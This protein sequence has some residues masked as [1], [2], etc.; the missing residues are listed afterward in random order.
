MATLIPVLLDAST[1]AAERRVAEALRDQLPADWVVV[2]GQRLATSRRGGTHLREAEIDVLVLAPGLG[3]ACLE[4]K[5]GREVGCDGGGWYSVDERGARHDIKDPGRQAQQSVHQLVD[6][7]RALPAPSLPN[8]V[9]PFVWGVVLPG[10][11]VDRDVGPA[12]PRSLV[13]DRRDLADPRTAFERLFQTVPAR[14]RFGADDARAVLDAVAPQF[15][16]VAALS[17]DVDAHERLLVRLTDEQLDVVDGLDEQRRVVLQ[18]PAGTGKTMIVMERA[19]RLA[20][21]GARVLVVCYNKLLAARLQPSARGFRVVHFHGLCHE[22]CKAGGTLAELPDP[23]ALQR[24][25][26]EEAPGRMVEAL[27]RLTDRRFDAVL[28][29]EGQ[30]FSPGMW[31][32]V[33]ALLADR[34][35][36]YL[37]AC[38]DPE[39]NIYGGEFP[40]DLNMQ[41]FNLRVNCRNSQPI[42][43]FAYG[44]VGVEPRLR[45]DAPAS[46]E[47]TTVP[48]A[49]E[50]ELLAG[51]QQ[52]IDALTGAGR[53]APERIVV[54]SPK[55][56][57]KS[58]VWAH[59][60]F[61]RFTLEQ[62]ADGADAAAAQ[63]KAPPA[64]GGAAQ[65]ANVI[66]FST[67]Q[68]FKG[69]EADAVILC[70]IGSST[71]PRWVYVAASRAK[72]VLWCVSDARSGDRPS[73]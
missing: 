33:T 35:R 15:R 60:R 47:V 58:A 46:P 71:A 34:E 69:L 32:A 22:L 61:G 17:A 14:R 20:R 39:Q 24:F 18:G 36:S 59:R 40:S 54:L 64:A 1:P 4:I 2:H 45:P 30:D 65:A 9:P 11:E 62:F 66:R 44:K 51:V 12:L 42:A 5:G 52:A 57:K 25:Y 41:P 21:D 55:S 16:L 26:R 10:V 73:A 29:D 70:E 53:L 19:R 50:P 23:G 72:H 6:Y 27:A 13:L 48:Y 56:A 8:G 43:R 38:F 28:V 49:T 31:A 7:L 63:V 67:L 3:M 37:W 68:G